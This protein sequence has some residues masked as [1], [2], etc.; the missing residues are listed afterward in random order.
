MPEWLSQHQQ[1][2]EHIAAWSVAISLV[3]L[4]FTLALLPIVVL[5]LPPDYFLKED[6]E[7][8]RRS[9]LHPALVMLGIVLKNII[10]V[11]LI[12]AGL[13]MV[14]IP[15]QGLLTM[16]VGLILT[17]FPGKFALEQRLVKRPLILRTMN[18]LRV[19]AGRPP[20]LSPHTDHT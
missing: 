4:L 14:F 10:G 7:P 19:R 9:Q 17:N 6:R 13:L 20:L 3:S 16:L 11:L 5:R 18:R 2:L 12:I 15:G 8:A 1:S